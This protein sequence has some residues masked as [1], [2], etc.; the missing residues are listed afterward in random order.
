M[1]LKFILWSKKQLQSKCHIKKTRK[2]AKNNEKL[3]REREI[4]R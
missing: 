1:V 4:S 2:N 3:I